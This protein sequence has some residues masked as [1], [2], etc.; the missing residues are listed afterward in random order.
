MTALAAGVFVPSW[1]SRHASATAAVAEA[2]AT[3]SADI[4]EQ[5]LHDALALS[6]SPLT[7]DQLEA[8]WVSVTGGNHRPAAEGLG[9]R[10]WFRR[11]AELMTPLVER[12]GREAG[13]ADAVDPQDPVVGQVVDIVGRLSF[14]SNFWRDPVDEGFLRTALADLARSGRPELAL[15]LFISVAVNHHARLDDD[16][17]A[18]V[19]R[20]GR[21]FGYGDHLLA[22]LEH[23]TGS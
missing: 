19:W 3:V 21:R 5:Y 8:V 20:T 10:A 7:N 23:L 2:V 15:R 14:R 12:A 4:A 6:G 11:L 22:R 9:G 18:A 13:E 17:E 16:L 1:W